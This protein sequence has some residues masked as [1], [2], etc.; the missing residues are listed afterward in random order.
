M[1]P[2]KASKTIKNISAD[3]TK[4]IEERYLSMTQEQHI[5]A[6]PDTYVGDIQPQTEPM[7]VYCNQRN[8]IIKKKI[9]YVPGLYKIFDEIIVNARDQT[10]VDRS[11]DTIM[12]NVNKTTGEISVMNNGRGIDVEIHA[13]HNIYVPELIFGKLLTSTNYD[14]NEQRTTGGR[15]GY[16]AKLT[17]IF[18]QKF[19]VEIVDF[20]RKRRFYQ[21]FSKNMTEKSVPKIDNLKTCK[22]G[23]TKIS[24]IPDFARF[25]LDRLTDDME[26]LIK[27]RVYDLAGVTNRK[28]IYYND[29]KINC[30]D[31]E[32]YLKLYHFDGMI[33]ENE[34]DDEKENDITDDTN[35]V[36]ASIEADKSYK[37]YFERVNSSW[38]IGY[39]YAPD[40]GNDQISF[41]NGICTY[42]GGT[43]VT[44]VTDI[45]INKLKELVLKKH[46]D[47]TIKPNQIK[48]NLIVFVKATIINPSFTSQTKETLK[49]K[50]S[51]FGSKCDIKDKMLVDFSKSGILNQVVNLIKLKEQAVLKKTDGKKITKISGIPKLEDANLAGGKSSEN[52][53]LIL[54][55][56]D[57]AKALA[58][59]GRSVTGSDRF[60]IFALKGK[61]LNVREAT[62]KQL[63]EN[64]EII[65]IK[66]IMGLQH[67]KEYTDL[68]SLRYGKIIV[69]TDQD[70]VTGDTPITLRNSKN[71]I[72]IKTINSLCNKWSFDNEKLE[73]DNLTL[74]TL[75]EYGKLEDYDVWTDKGWTKIN[76]IMR[77]KVSKR[78]FR[79]LTHTGC[80]DVTEDHSLLK[81]DGSKIAPNECKVDDYLLHNNFYF[82]NNRI[83]I[84][85][86]LEEINIRKLHDIAKDLKIQRYQEATKNELINQINIFKNKTYISES[87]INYDIS[88]E[89][90]YVMGLFFADGTCNVYKWQ[91]TYKNKATPCEYTSNRT[92]YNWAIS[93]TN[94]LFLEKAK[95]ILEK[96]YNYEFV[97][98][99]DRHNS[100]KENR[101]LSYKL[102]MN[103]CQ[104]TVDIIT[105]YRN[106]FYD[107]HKFKKLPIEILN[108]S[109]DAR[110]NFFHGYYDG[111]GHKGIEW[112]NNQSTPSYECNKLMCDVY[113][114][115]TTQGMYYL[116]RSIGY[117]VTINNNNKKP[118]VYTLN[119]TK[120]T[121]QDNPNRIKKIIDL[122]ITEQ[123]VYDLETENHHFQAGVGS[124]IV[125]NT[126]GYHIK[127]LL[128]NFIHYFWPS[129]LKIP[130]FISSLA[131]PIVK[132]TKG[133][134]ELVFYNIPDYEEWKNTIPKGYQIK[135]YKGLGTSSAKEAREYFTDIEEKLINYLDDKAAL[136]EIFITDENDDD[137]ADDDDTEIYAEKSNNINSNIVTIKT[138]I[139]PKYK[140]AC[141]ESITLAFERKRADDRKKWLASYN[142][143]VRLDNSNK[144]VPIK[145]FIDKELIHF[146][147]EDNNRSIPSM[148]DGLKNSQRKVLYGTRMKRLNSKSDE[149]RVAQLAGYVSEKT[150]YHHGEASLTGTIVGMAQN[151][152]GSNNINIL[153]PSGQFGTRVLGGKDAA[154]ARYIHTYLGELTKYIF[155]QDDDP[156]LNYLD[157]DGIQIEPE[158]FVPIIPMILVNGSEGIGTGFSTKVPCYNPLTII[159]NLLA[160]IDDKPVTN[161]YPWYKNFKGIINSVPDKP[162]NF[163]TY[164]V[165]SK[166]DNEHLRITELPVG[167]W[168]TD[169]KGFLDGLETK[170]YI[171]N[172]IANNTEELIDIVIEMDEDKISTG[173]ANNSIFNKLNLITKKSI[174]NMHLYNADGKIKKYHNPIE[175]L[176]DFYD[177]R[178]LTYKKRKEYIINKLTKE[179]NILNYKMKFIKDI[180]DKHIVIERRKKQDIINR[181]VEL[182]YPQLATDD[183]NESYD[184]L[185]GMPLFS[186]TD[187]KIKELEDKCKNKEEELINIE[188][189][190]EEDIWIKE[191]NELRSEYLI[192]L[193]NNKIDTNLVA[194]QKTKN[195][196]KS[197]KT[198]I[199]KPKAKSKQI[200]I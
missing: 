87:K 63:L 92:S 184:Y 23:Y 111:D 14:D 141:T 54:T 67:D 74:L 9:T 177:I 62:A 176:E 166:I 86:N 1:A 198:L 138:N 174:T 106:M 104:A 193:E 46:K 161:M 121:I 188:G 94:L 79:V 153:Y 171:K 137:D 107:D 186:L 18:S 175:I 197:V 185:I 77:H 154:S 33:D 30:N 99:E 124:M 26:S 113:G 72:E 31:F 24:F 143:Q 150:C 34:H 35:S 162:Q 49:T 25:K 10:E 48:D 148:C 85:N 129:L 200:E 112:Y 3:G 42:N 80:V 155:R 29:V 122:G 139:K 173:L 169:Y 140:D 123:Y 127:G 114:K 68:S 167:T 66:K 89:E 110:F 37:I 20:Q 146:S 8:K 192:W 81:I 133:K 100:L 134:E 170:G 70:S 164:G 71:E 132:A 152:V 182:E 90:A 6:R 136:S 172:Y 142:R 47:V 191:L 116:C 61:L 126:D 57:S 168:T 149:I 160:M 73:Y 65:C 194:N 98:I 103:G 119:L 183:K 40:N 109:Y 91:H 39:M 158:Y 21:E 189:T 156:I 12:V 16:G 19:T 105:K 151:Y 56:G 199:G 15:N 157:D 180:L 27:K 187:E 97:I 82:E 52:C 13:E 83:D 163:M 36:D 5:L 11:C 125:H 179:L 130:K 32:N 50:I 7:F 75:K 4:S 51:D 2:N 78:I 195:K 64:E 196:T 115:I 190:S 178:I 55:E 128:L 181:L 69:M 59:S 43:H 22:N 159:D 45:I 95:K 84:P 76:K 88:A 120:G 41:V 144:I 38:E 131:T 135:Y 44:H 58:M 53:C 17:N 96:Q 101:K 93:N 145:D 108:S 118:N 117:E 165:C 102:Q 28:R 60:G 147:E